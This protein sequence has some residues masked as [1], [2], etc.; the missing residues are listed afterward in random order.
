MLG[1]EN[2]LK[3]ELDDQKKQNQE[4]IDRLNLALLF[5]QKLE[6]YV[7]NPSDVLNKA[8]L[9]DNMAKNPVS[10]VKVIPIL[11]DFVEKIEEL[12]DD[13]RS[14]FDGLAPEINLAVP[15][16]IVFD[17]SGDIPSLIGWGKES[18]PTKTPTKPDQL[19]P[20]EPTKETEDVPPHTK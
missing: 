13:M 17:I 3:G 20:S 5:N 2:K 12:L 19:G 11:V 16:E 10:A 14:L 7:G 15:L 6:E 1:K 18:A 8:R 4:A 9:F